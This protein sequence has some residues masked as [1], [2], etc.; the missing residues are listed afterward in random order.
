MVNLNP[1]ASGKPKLML[2]VFNYDVA[3]LCHKNPLDS[4]SVPIPSFHFNLFDS[5]GSWEFI[6]LTS[7]PSDLID[8]AGY[9]AL[10]NPVPLYTLSISI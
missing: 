6:F 9:Y 7:A 3:I 4:Y 5:G 10:R 1:L 8:I 2:D